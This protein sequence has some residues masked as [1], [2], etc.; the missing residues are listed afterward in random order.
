MKIEYYYDGQ[1]RR[2]LLH[3]IR[4]FSEFQIMTGFNDDGSP[5]FR[6][7]PCRYMDFSRQA[8]II[9]AGA[10]ENNM[11]YAP[12]ITISVQSLKMD[13]KNVRSPVHINTVMGTNKSPD[14]NEY[15]DELEEQYHVRR[16]NP[17]PWEFVFDVNIWTT[18]LTNKMELWEQ[19]ATLFSPSAVLK[20]SMN[21]MDW[22]AEETVELISANFTSKGIPAGTTDELDIA[23][24]SFQT[25]VWF[26]LPANVQK[27]NIIKQINANIGLARDEQELEAGSYHEV[28]ADV[29]TPKDLQ[30]RM[31][32]ISTAIDSEMYE[33]QLLNN[34]GKPVGPKGGS[35]SWKVYL[36]YLNP[37]WQDRGLYLKLNRTVEDNN[38]VRGTLVNLG[39]GD[40]VGKMVV[41]V[42][43]STFNVKYQ[44]Q[45]FVSDSTV[46]RKGDG[47]LYIAVQDLTVGGVPV[48]ANQIFQYTDEGVTIIPE[49]E[50]TSSVY[51][52]DTQ[53]YY[54]YS[55]AFGWYETVLTN[56]KPGFWRIAFIN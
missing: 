2:S 21:P 35:L 6:K 17:V 53:K 8:Q 40:D 27:A 33:V 26:S 22:T 30:V 37:G 28:I 16:F 9:M 38:P 20:T 10:S 50:Y 23:T 39:T 56:Y 31:T 45:S 48:P 47:L 14:V 1:F 11:N 3:I 19:I 49:S 18:N 12:L 34:A 7:V 43:R 5:Q 44:V 13:R 46:P 54:V 51:V 42:E 52:I 32:R 55:S 29:F 36:D 4:M 15:T 24:L 41:Q 25:T